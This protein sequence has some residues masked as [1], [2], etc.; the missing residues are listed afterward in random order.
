MR[1][2][3][4]NTP[5]VVLSA[6]LCASLHLLLVRRSWS[7]PRNLSSL[8]DE[9]HRRYDGSRGIWCQ[10]SAAGGSGIQ[11]SSGRLVIPAY[12]Y[13]CPHVV[14]ASNMWISVSLDGLHDAV[15]SSNC[16]LTIGRSRLE[17]EVV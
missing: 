2:D 12:H 11:T 10:T 3:R 4:Q 1:G 15:L 6:V 9:Q 16:R 13:D 17:L 7:A 8:H 14:E 5:R